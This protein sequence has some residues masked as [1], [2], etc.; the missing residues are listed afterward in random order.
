MGRAKHKGKRVNGRL[1][2]ARLEIV[3]RNPPPDHILARRE[4]FS[5]VTAPKGGSIDQDI[6]DGIGQ[7]CVLDMLGGT[8]D[9]IQMRTRGREWGLHYA[10]L[11]RLS[12]FK[13]GSY[14]RMA[15]GFAQ[16]YITGRDLQF[17]RMHL[18]LGDGNEMAALLSLIV[19][20]IVGSYPT[21]GL[22]QQWYE[23][24]IAERLR[25]KHGKLVGGARFPDENDRAWLAAAKR[26]L[27]S[28]VDGALPSRGALAA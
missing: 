13:A 15:K 9:P 4:L 10:Q 24:L 3:D 14:E 19:D 21:D 1:S 20:P 25:E 6:H 23:A 11:L 12:G 26:G 2:R 17:D 28:L 8:I 16:V 22:W 27:W 5:F 18:A 7:L